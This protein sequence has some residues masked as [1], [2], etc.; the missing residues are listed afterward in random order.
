MEDPE[1]DLWN[2]QDARSHRFAIG[3]GPVDP[4][5]VALDFDVLFPLIRGDLKIFG[6]GQRSAAI[7]VC[8]LSRNHQRVGFDEGARGERGTGESDFSAGQRFRKGHSRNAGDIL[9][10]LT[11]NPPSHSC[12]GL[13]FAT[14]NALRRSLRGPPVLGTDWSPRDESRSDHLPRFAVS[15]GPKIPASGGHRVRRSSGEETDRHDP[16]GVADGS[17]HSSQTR[18]PGRAGTING[19]QPEGESSCPRADAF[20]P[21]T[22]MPLQASPV[23]PATSSSGSGQRFG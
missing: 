19:R 22:Q 6:A 13:V 10:D 18:S 2:E 23:V 20:T 11:G 1:R 3:G 21:E 9:G 7:S 16:G 12:V 15:H 14:G 4:P 5:G 8:E 17:Q